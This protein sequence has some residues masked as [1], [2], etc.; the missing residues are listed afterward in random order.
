MKHTGQN[1]GVHTKQN[2]IVKK[3]DSE[4]DIANARTKEAEANQNP[5]RFHYSFRS[6]P[7]ERSHLIDRVN[8]MNP[9][10]CHGHETLYSHHSVTHR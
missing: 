10:K 3:D 9:Q 7:L 4:I 8:E 6:N 5:P 1:K 2:N